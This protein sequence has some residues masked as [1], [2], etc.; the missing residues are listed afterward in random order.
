MY[1]EYQFKYIALI[2][3]RILIYSIT[4]RVIIYLNTKPLA[5]SNE[6]F[7]EI[8]MQTY[9]MSYSHPTTYPT[10]LPY[11]WDGECHLTLNQPFYEPLCEIPAG[12]FTDQLVFDE[13]KDG[14]EF[15]LGG[16]LSLS[17]SMDCED[18]EPLQTESVVSFGTLSTDGTNGNAK[19][20]KVETIDEQIEFI[21]ESVK[22]QKKPVSKKMPTDKKKKL[23][24]KRKTNDQLELL[25]KEI[26]EAEVM[27][28]MKIRELAERTGLKVCQVYKWYWD[29]KRKQAGQ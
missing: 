26:S 4:I 29:Y 19:G 27:N 11:Q 3:I 14:M 12:D 23:T 15:S 5:M 20:E 16:A 25:Q 10:Q 7:E 2:I 1:C 24:R 28:R 17:M 9:S 8:E 18:S 13:D 6:S 21:L 22:K